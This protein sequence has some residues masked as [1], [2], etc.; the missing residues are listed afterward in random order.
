MIG[1]SIE[2]D[3]RGAQNFGM[4]AIFFNPNKLDKPDDVPMQ[5]H[6]LAQLIDWF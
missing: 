2:A 1:D 3:I 5:I 4:D 6:N